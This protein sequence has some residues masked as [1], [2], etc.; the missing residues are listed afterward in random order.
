MIVPDPG[1]RLELGNPKIST[2][3]QLQ[4]YNQTLGVLQYLG[5]VSLKKIKISITYKNSQ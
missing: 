5:T 3:F 2:L 1:L 4:I